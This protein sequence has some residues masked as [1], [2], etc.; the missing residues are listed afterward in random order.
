MV[1]REDRSMELYLHHQG[2]VVSFASEP[3]A[4][5][6]E[7]SASLRGGL[8]ESASAPLGEEIPVALFVEDSGT[9][10]QSLGPEVYFT[11]EETAGYDMV[12]VVTLEFCC[13]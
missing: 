12:Q 11:P 7:T 1:Y 9:A 2:G 5:P 6:G 3:V 13:P 10:M 8:Q 4:F